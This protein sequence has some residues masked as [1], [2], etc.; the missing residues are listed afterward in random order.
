MPYPQTRPHLDT[1]TETPS[2]GVQRLGTV[3]QRGELERVTGIKPTSLGWKPKA[4][5][6]YHTRKFCP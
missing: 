3:E 1:G 5:S 4:Q 2:Q 6:L